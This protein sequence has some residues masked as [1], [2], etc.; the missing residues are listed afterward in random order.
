M[1]GVQGCEEGGL[2]NPQLVD[3]AVNR[4]VIRLRGLVS[5]RGCITRLVYKGVKREE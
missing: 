1:V 3:M 2:G 5:R 4:V